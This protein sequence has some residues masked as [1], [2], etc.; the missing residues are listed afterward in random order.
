ME[1]GNLGR[2]TTFISYAKPE[3][4]EYILSQSTAADTL[5]H[6]SE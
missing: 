4:L 2:Q 5:P 1:H 3:I 6:E